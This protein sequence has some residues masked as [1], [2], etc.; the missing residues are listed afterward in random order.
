MIAT[1]TVA[2]PAIEIQAAV[3]RDGRFVAYVSDASSQTEVH[4]QP[5]PATGAKWIIS[6]NASGPVWSWDGRELYYASGRSMMAVPFSTENGFSA[7]TPRKLFD[8][9]PQATL[10]ADTWTTYDVAP[11]GRFLMVRSGATE[12][13]GRQLVLVLNWFA[14]LEKALAAGRS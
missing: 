3:S 7:G 9:P 11:D 8:F 14:K 5:F 1:A 10:T 12:A 4:V 6:D 2:T 13:T